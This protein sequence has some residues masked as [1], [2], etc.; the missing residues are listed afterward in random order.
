[1]EILTR[2]SLRIVHVDDDDDFAELSARGLRRAGFGQPI[3]R[4]SGGLV[5][6]HCFSEMKPESAPHVILLDLQMPGMSG[7]E[8]L[9]WVRQNY[10]DRN[11]AVY[12]LTSSEDPE[13]RKQAKANGVTEYIIKA[14]V[15]E[16]LIEKLDFLIAANN[17]H[18]RTSGVEASETLVQPA[19]MGLTRFSVER[20]G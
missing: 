6:L 7:L 18:F 10:N 3:T 5:A 20:Q 15:S 2:D 17:D 1:V 13:H 14:T 9:H 19:T 16:R 11:V 4:C 12:L 8:V